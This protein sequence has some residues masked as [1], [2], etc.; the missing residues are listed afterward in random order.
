MK[1]LLI[2]WNS[3]K[4]ALQELRVNKLR[5]FLSLFGI[6]IGI[7][8]V[9]GVLSTIDSL[10]RKIEKDFE[11]FANNTIYIDKWEYGGG[12]NGSPWWNFINRPVMKYSEMQQLKANSQQAADISFF[13]KNYSSVTNGIAT[14]NNV[15]VFGVT[16]DFS[17]IQEIEIGNGRY[18][19]QSEFDHGTPTAIIGYTN[20]Q[21]LFGSA[22]RALN[23][24]ISFRGKHVTI[25][26]ILKKQGATLVSIFDYDK[27]LIL[28]YNNFT[29]IWRSDYSE[30]KILVKARPTVA[31]AALLDELHGIMRQV[32][33]LTPTQ[34]DDFTLN[35]V[36][37]FGDQIGSLFGSINLGGWLI[38]GLS[39]IVGGFGVANI[40]FVTVRERTSQI[41]L[42]KA[43]GAKSSTIL[44][45]FLL[46]S[47]FLCVIGGL[48]GLF[49]VWVLTKIL[50]GI[51]P[52]PISIA[53]FI[54]LLALSIC[55]ILGILSGIIPARIAAK[56]NA[57]DAIRSK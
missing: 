35:D 55:I 43:I 17:K 33:K 40:M 34:A 16:E 29:T 8:C 5:T 21:D 23:Q 53:P 10:Q 24:D 13:V 11:G 37:S 6:T 46:E 56:M 54:I 25:V 9:I 31:K 57:V 42:K 19:S 4:M 7:F 52:F 47:A 51:L 44:L 2:I 20:A 36:S 28:T 32:R 49:L 1:L 27:C 14:L 15:D 22:E 30:P 50:S 18:F 38:A 39:L 26:G 45:E 48:I 12:P 41:G 3:F